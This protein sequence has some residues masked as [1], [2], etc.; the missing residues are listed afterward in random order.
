MYLDCQKMKA[1]P[2]SQLTCKQNIVA[3]WTWGFLRYVCG[4]TVIQTDITGGNVT[5]IRT[6]QQ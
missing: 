1:E 6:E 3:V 5:H 4:Q 2:W